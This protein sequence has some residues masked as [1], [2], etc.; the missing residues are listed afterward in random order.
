[1]RPG[2]KPKIS[3]TACALGTQQKILKRQCP[4]TFTTYKDTKKE[5]L[6]N[7]FSRMHAEPAFTE[8]VFS[9]DMICD[10]APVRQ[11]AFEVPGAGKVALASGQQRQ[12]YGARGAGA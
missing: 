3:R 1:M 8:D 9:L 5:K 6:E 7:L 2:Q 10:K 12:N 11:P 4:G